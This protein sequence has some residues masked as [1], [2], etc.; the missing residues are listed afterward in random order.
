MIKI[1][2]L[3]CADIA[4]RLIIPNMI[5]SGLYEIV[6]VA[7]RSKEK[8]QEFAGLFNCEPII[9]YENLLSRKDIEAIYVPLPTG[10]HYEW[11]IKGLNAGKH[12]F[13]EKSL[14]NEY[15]EVKAIVDLAIQKNLC[16]FE[17]FMF[18]FHSQFDAVKSV[19][20]DYFN[21][22]DNGE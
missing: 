20:A 11:I 15:T 17:N 10:M 7:S 19:I 9:G 3:G 6:A 12:I 4:K 22:N 14:A 8:A 2:V 16:V 1:G 5:K 18:V 13:A 21:K